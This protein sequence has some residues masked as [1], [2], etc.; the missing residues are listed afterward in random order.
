MTLLASFG[1]IAGAAWARFFVNVGALPMPWGWFLRPSPPFSFAVPSPCELAARYNLELGR[2]TCSLCRLG[3]ESTKQLNSFG[4]D[5]QSIV[6]KLLDEIVPA[7]TPETRGTFQLKV[8][9]IRQAL[10]EATQDGLDSD[11]DGFDNDLELLFGFLPGEAQS[12][13]SLSVETPQN[14]R[15]RLRQ[16]P[17][18]D[19]WKPCCVGL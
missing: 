17:K 9:Q 12:R 4:Q 10:A 6:Y 5:F 13:P 19:G 15:T 8:A 14:Y 18:K 16:Q 11:Q 2:A 3:K 7:D 1:F